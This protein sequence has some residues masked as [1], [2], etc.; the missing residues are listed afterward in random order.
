VSFLAALLLLAAREQ[1]DST[2]QAR[3]SIRTDD[4]KD[5]VRVLAGDDYEGRNAG[6]EGSEKAAAYVES[7]FKEYGL[8]PAVGGGYRQTFSFLVRNDGERRTTVFR[9]QAETCNVIGEIRGREKPE[10]F[11]VVG[12]H[13]DHVGKRGQWN[14]GRRNQKK[15]KD[16]EVWNGADDN[17]SGVA[18]LL[19]LAQ[20]FSA[21]KP[22]RTVVFV[23]FGA[24]EHGLKGS[25]WYRFHPARPL[26]N[27]G[28]MANLDM[29]G[30]APAAG[31]QI[32]GTG[33]A[34]GLRAMVQKAVAENELQAQLFDFGDIR[35][36]DSDHLWFYGAGIPTLFF[37][38]GLHEDYHEPTDHI[39]KLDFASMEK[40]TRTAFRVV[41]SAAEA[42]EKLAFEAGRRLGIVE[43]GPLDET[44][45]T[46]HLKLPKGQGA[47]WVMDVRAGSP[48]AAA[49]F[50]PFDF[51]VEFNGKPLPQVD[52]R[53]VLNRLID[54]APAGQ[55]I[56]VVVIRKGKREELKL[57]F[58]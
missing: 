52:P 31:V 38:S 1:D 33:T 15:I 36:P 8:S 37:F 9:K 32:H 40:T 45:T 20:A 16:D 4:L 56:P 55:T 50:Q 13:Y 25:E 28:L 11:V 3:E 57:Q 6:M 10:E 5:H 2:K 46:Q 12:A 24:E 18:G 34:A 47:L 27:T 51:L 14:P 19:E 22:R 21:L 49:K 58:P 42:P 17:A 44:S 35:E 41:W 43:F 30:R 29:I 53:R 48:A 39:E 23:A 54:E 26:E 7:K